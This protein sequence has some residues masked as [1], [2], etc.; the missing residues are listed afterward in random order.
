MTF[1]PM[2]ILIAVGLFVSMLVVQELGR[3]FGRAQLR[4]DPEGGRAG[5]GP[6]ESAIL[7]L[8]GLLLAFTFNGAATRF[9]ARRALIAEEVNAL[10]TA[11]RRLDLLAEGP[12]A[13]LQEKFREYVR[14]RLAAYAAVEDLA[15]ARRHLAR[16]EELQ[17]EIWLQVVPASTAVGGAIPMLVLTPINQMFDVATKRQIATQSH[18]PPALYLMLGAMTILSAFPAG[19]AMA[20][21]A[22]RPTLHMFLFAGTLAIA[23]FVTID[24]EYPRLGLINIDEADKNLVKVLQSMR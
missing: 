19:Y 12:R 7:A 17:D 3:R 9:E 2:T 10:G 18:P 14:E 11:Y 6:I 22:T 24:L 8:L 15:L 23:I 21:R 13:A 1:V 5:V 4:R 20:Q 16:S